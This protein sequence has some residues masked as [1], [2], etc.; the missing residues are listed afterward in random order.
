MLS[1]SFEFRSLIAQNTK[2]EVKATLYVKRTDGGAGMRAVSLTGPDFMSGEWSF[3]DAVSSAGSFDVGSAIINQF[4]FTLNNYTRKFDDYDFTGGYI[5][6]YVGVRLSNGG[7]EWLRKGRFYIE[8]PETYG[9]TIHIKALDAMC[10]L[11]RPYNE[12]TTRYPA[13][14]R[15]I[16]MNI[17]TKCGVTLNNTYFVNNDFVV[18]ER[19]D[20]DSLT[21]LAMLS[22][23]AQASGNWARFNNQGYLR[24]D[25]YNTAA[26]E[27]E[28]WLDGGTYTTTTRPYSDGDTADGGNFTDYG[29]GDTVE[30]GEF[31]SNVYASIF[32]YSSASIVTDDVV[33]TGVRVTAQDKEQDEGDDLEGETSL[34]GSEGYVL[35]FPDNPL[36]QYGTAA[37]VAERVGERVVGMRFR[38]FDVSALGDPSIE[39]GDPIILTDHLQ[40]QYC[41]Y[42][43]RLTYK[44][45]AYET[46][47]CNAE[48]PSRHSAS[49]YSAATRAVVKLRNS[50]T[51]EKTDRE[52]AIENLAEQL[53]QSA[54]LYMTVRE[55]SD[56]SNIYYMHD[57]PTLAE[58]KVVW[59]LNA[60]AFGISTD[61]G[62]TYPYGLDVTGN[63][64]LNRIYTIGLDATYVNAGQLVVGDPENPMLLIDMETGDVR[65]NQLAYMGNR[66]VRGVLDDVDATITSVDVEY[67]QNQSSTTA[68]TNGWATNSPIWREGYYIWQRTKTVSGNGVSYSNP[69][70][71]SGRD[72]ANGTPGANGYVHVAWANSADGSTG[73]STTVSTDKA[74]IGVYTDNRLADST[75]YRDYSWSKIK[76]DSGIGVSAIVEEYYL[77]SS[78]TTQTGGSWSTLEPAW[79]SGHYIWTRSKITWSDGN[80]TRTDPVLAKALNGANQKAEDASK[81][82][83]NYLSYDSSSG[84]DVGYSGTSAKTR[85]SGSG[86]EIFDSAGSSAIYAGVQNSKSIVRVGR[87]SGSGNIVMSSEGYVDIRYGSTIL[88]H[89]GYGDGNNA[90]GSKT[91]AAYYTLGV[92]NADSYA[93]IGNYSVAEALNNKASGYASHAE[94][95][96]TEAS[97]HYSHTEGSSTKTYRNC[98]HAEGR[99]TVA[100]TAPG[101]SNMYAAHAEG[102]YTTATGESSHAEGYDTTA[103]GSYSHAGGYYTTATDE[104]QTVIGAYNVTDTQSEMKYRKLLIIGAGTSSSNRKN[105]FYVQGNGKVWCAGTLTQNSDRRLKEHHKYLGDDACDFVRNLKPALYTKDGERHVGF[106]AQDVRDVEPDG[107]NTATV[108]AQHT[109]ESLGFDPLTLD[110]TAL[111]AP[112]TAYAQSLERRIDE[113]QETINALLAR[114]E[115]LEAN[116]K[117]VRK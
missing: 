71:I 72:G 19:P 22:Y 33:I 112:L 108:T 38:P 16:V 23:A 92:R 87:T 37:D 68:P 18:Q 39:A 109:D 61:G 116:S 6:P 10:K 7:V 17:C 82:A 77:S 80:V 52:Q 28:D 48:T 51:R 84:L 86:V 47:A 64:I 100:G 111:I 101:S 49:S 63:A 25:W 56:G 29:S 79:Q 35:E 98:C 94:G 41:S 65:I 58:S 73:F 74:Y 106:Y 50:I 113:Q 117:E 4:E 8:Q 59:K 75:N 88:A 42:I 5:D 30:G 2:V 102:S 53:A 15:T 27:S 60:N 70:C 69:V 31:G 1:T 46:Y 99:N 96:N 40:N 95:N 34:Y 36:I 11:E 81:V 76:G 54:G 97:G 13:S 110:Y 85:V 24:L 20:D 66:T 89:F 57:K 67:A 90:F 107:W 91:T 21:C 62:K 26:F 32:A 103:S 55:Q 83:T 12:V 44:V 104:A 93:D 114:V 43:T 3:N 105:A 115:A 14:L 45:G 9:S 78:S